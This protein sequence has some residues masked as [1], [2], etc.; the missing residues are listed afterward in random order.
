MLIFIG[1]A[2]IISAIATLLLTF[3]GQTEAEATAILIWLV[4]GLL[5]LFLFSRSKLIDRALRWIIKRG[6][7][8]F[9]SLKIYDYEEL[10]GVSRG[11]S[12]GKFMVKKGSWLENKKLSDLRLNEEGVI[13]LAVYKKIKNGEMFIGAPPRDITVSKGDVLICYGPEENIR[14]LSER[15]KGAAGDKAHR[16]AVEKERAMREEEDKELIQCGALEKECDD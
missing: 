12:I 4:I 11:Y 15:L 2:G 5:I 13:V 10:L 7:E 8:R 9:T 1:N 3:I 6:L 16:E 14:N